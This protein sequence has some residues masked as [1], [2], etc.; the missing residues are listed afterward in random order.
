MALDD[1]L[2][3]VRWGH[4]HCVDIDFTEQGSGHSDGGRY[5]NFGRLVNLTDMAQAN[6]P[7]DVGRYLWPPKVFQQS[8]LSSKKTAMSEVVMHGVQNAKLTVSWYE[9]LVFT[10]M[11]ALPEFTVDK[12]ER[13]SI[14]NN[15]GKCLVVK[16]WGLLEVAK[17]LFY[18]L[19]A[20]VTSYSF[21]GLGD[22]IVGKRVG[23]RRQR[24]FV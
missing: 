8:S 4:E 5:Q 10:I 12:K 11:I 21:W 22:V 24:N 16:A 2:E 15:S 9:K 23:T 14:A 20:M 17:P 7:S 1:V 3:L 13:G 19:D 18:K 6:I